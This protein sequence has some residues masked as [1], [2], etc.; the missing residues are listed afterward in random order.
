VPSLATASLP[1]LV[2]GPVR[3]RAVP[4]ALFPS[5]SGREDLVKERL[6]KLL[7]TLGAPTSPGLGRLL[8]QLCPSGG[9][10]LHSLRLPAGLG[11]RFAGVLEHVA[12]VPRGVVVIAPGWTSQRDAGARGASTAKEPAVGPVA[13][14][15][16]EAR[17]D[18]GWR[19]GRRDGERAPVRGALARAHALRAWLAE[20]GWP[21]APVF[22]AACSAPV[23]GPL[24]PQPVLIGELWVG[25]A[26]RLPAWLGSGGGIAPADR[27][28]S[29]HP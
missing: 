1:R 28:L 16:P 29:R 13:A 20:S 18:K 6:A 19:D 23:A 2:A 9:T 22:A 27:A 14:L 5:G 17:G 26:E 7:A 10:V 24:V 25:P 3:G 4:S 12:V 11:D 21:G 15:E 8:D